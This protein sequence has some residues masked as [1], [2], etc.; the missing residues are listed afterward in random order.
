MFTY[1][2]SRNP[3]YSTNSWA[4]TNVKFSTLLTSSGWW[5]SSVSSFFDYYS[6][7]ETF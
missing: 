4:A 2:Q 6:A 1:P 7:G 3:C 5:F